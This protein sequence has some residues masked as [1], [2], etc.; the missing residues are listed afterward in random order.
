MLASSL[1]LT[2]R[3]PSEYLFPRAIAPSTRA[4]HRQMMSTWRSPVRDGADPVVYPTSFGAD[5]T[6]KTDSAAAF[7]AAMTA[8]LSRASGNMSDGILDLGGVVMDLQGGDFLLSS[9]LTVPQFV[10]NMRIIDGTLRATPNFPADRYVLEIGS[11]PCNTPSGQ[12]SCNENIGMSGL[13]L[14]GSH[15][16]AGCLHIAA[17][18][19]A[20]LDSSSAIFG[21][22]K[23]GILLDGGHES[24]ISETWVAAYFWSDPL[25]E[26]NNATGIAIAGNDHFLTNVIVFSARVGV[27]LTGAANK[28]VNVHTWN[29]ATGNGGIGILNSASQNI[30]IGCY[31]DFTDF[32][33]RNPNFISFSSGFFLGG[34]QAVF[35]AQKP[36]DTVL[37]V[38]F[39]GNIWYDCSGP[40]FTV[41][42]TI[43]SFTSVIDVDLDGTAFCGYTKSKATGLTK[44]TKFGNFSASN[45][46]DFSDVLLFPS[47][48]ISSARSASP[49]PCPY[50]PVIGALP[51][52][53]DA[54]TLNVTV[55]CADVNQMLEITVDQSSRSS[56]SA[57]N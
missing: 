38:S 28:L 5:P 25:K 24:M 48:G 50:F 9:P 41:N 31:L 39:Y 17:T 43:G 57:A 35:E 46:I 52:P 14:D 49:G 20:T 4:A 22:V 15:V 26:R 11:R 3:V 8:V 1:A 23:N 44:A 29:D 27:A 13:T 7:A 53:G 37:G 51:G 12:G 34:A 56:T 33:M 30:F 21:F 47:A 45:L 6:G 54:L 40:S 16:A 18:M 55:S 42:E 10:G 19:G 32:V 36:G 2:V